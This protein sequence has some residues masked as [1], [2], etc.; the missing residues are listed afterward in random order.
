MNFTQ[1]L[2][3]SLVDNSV[4][5]SY[6]RGLQQGLSDLITRTKDPGLKSTFERMKQCPVKDQTGA[7]RGFMDYISGALL[8]NRC[9][10][11]DP[12]ESLS[13]IYRQL[14]S[15]TNLQG[16]PRAT[17]FSNFD[18][19]KPLGAGNP[20]EARF[21]TSVA[22]AVRNL[23]QTDRQQSQR[24]NLSIV[25]G[26]DKERAPSTVS[27]DEIPARNY[28]N[29][30]ELMD[31]IRELLVASQRENPGIPLVDLFNSI[32][33][34]E[35]VTAQ[36]ARFGFRRVE[37]GRKLIIDYVRRF[38]ETTENWALLRLLDKI[39][40]PMAAK[41]TNK[42][43]PI[44]PK[45][46]PD[47]QD[48]ASIVDVMKKHGGTVNLGRLQKDRRR[49]SEWKPR[50]ASSPHQNRLEDVMARMV[51][52]GIVVEKRTKNGGRFFVAGPRYV[53]YGGAAANG[54]NQA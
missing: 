19:T 21:K 35:N 43:K 31:G 52:D 7:C 37:L 40:D 53:K 42:P 33:A 13:Q 16:Q 9:G 2:Q 30:R 50:N 36:K 39:R 15:P 1:F 41:T 24:G 34:G 14:M 27:A 49:W 48:Y 46:T 29:E 45:L 51:A 38:A 3:E 25:S 5:A 6:E 26:R 23:C 22:N 47:Q 28:G 18:E 12:E 8:K 10:L 20:L 54:G 44:K 32:L 11:A 4:T 17:L